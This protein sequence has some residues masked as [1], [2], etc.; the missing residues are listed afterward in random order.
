MHLATG[1]AL[2]TGAAGTTVDPFA[3]TTTG[4]AWT[5]PCWLS[6]V[7]AYGVYTIFGGLG[8]LAVKALL[9]GLLAGVLLAIC[10]RGPV[11][12]LAVLCVAISLVALGPYLELRPVCVSYL[13]LAVTL[14]WLLR[15]GRRAERAPPASTGR[16]FLSYLPLLVLFAVWANLD[17]WFVLGPAVLVL[18]WL[19]ALV[20]YW[21]DGSWGTIPP[22][23]RAHIRG[24]SL[25]AVVGLVTPLVSPSHVRSLTVLPELLAGSAASPE[26]DLVVPGIG[27]PPAAVAYFCLIVVGVCAFL[28]N[29]A[30]LWW[31]DGLVWCALL[32]L[33]VHNKAATPFF[34]IVGGALA[35]LHL[36]SAVARRIVLSGAT[37][38]GSTP[39]GSRTGLAQLA[40]L[41]V[42]LAGL[43]AAWPGWLQGAAAEPRAWEVV[44]DP[45]LSEVGTQ[46][47]RWHDAGLNLGRGF[48]F[49]AASADAVAWLCPQAKDFVDDRP[50]LFPADVR[51]EDATV[52]RALLGG[53]S[54]WRGILRARQVTH[55]IVYDRVDGRLMTVLRRLFAAPREWRPIYLRGRTV[56]FAWA[57]AERSGQAADLAQLP[58]VDLS[59]RAFAPDESE[60]TAVTRPAPMLP[61]RTWADAYW[62]PATVP[63][64]GR[65]EALVYLAHFE[66]QR[67]AYLREPGAAGGCSR[68][69]CGGAGGAGRRSAGGVGH[70]RPAAL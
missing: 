65:G 18:W 33:S 36:Q 59:A 44:R 7:A 17:R 40:T 5:N 64:L 56:I 41:V 46:L 54:D 42:L 37:P 34:A 4:I 28:F 24:L 49:S 23:S 11:R 25:A 67:L 53:E 22:Y 6:D 45:S 20:H 55:L 29:G 14:W 16:A 1:R 69:R 9:I 66:S 52:K 48:H 10:W 38:R 43:A 21:I 51:N 12:W 19:G 30:R 39:R 32:A 63:N 68:G 15:V 13:L 26:A 61:A 70:W 35:G 47:A 62:R 31:S 57:A 50:G 3:Y 60:P 2:W 8:L 58:S 27:M